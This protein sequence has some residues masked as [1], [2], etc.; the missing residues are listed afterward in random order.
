MQRRRYEVDEINE[1]EETQEEVPK[2]WRLSLE[3]SRAICGEAN[4]IKHD[5]PVVQGFENSD[6]LSNKEVAE[7][8]SSE[9]PQSMFENYFADNA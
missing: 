1:N 7:Y 2:D 4:D 3:T 6:V 8:I 5:L 9:L